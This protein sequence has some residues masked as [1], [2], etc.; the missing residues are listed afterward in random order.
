MEPSVGKRA[1]AE[2][3][4]GKAGGSHLE[5]LVVGHHKVFH[6]TLAG[7]HD[8]HGVG[9]FVGTYAEEMLRRVYREQIHQFLRLD[10]VILDEGLNAV[11]VFLAAHVLMGAEVG[12]DIEALFFAEDAFE[13][14]V[15]KVEGVAAELVG[16]EQSFRA[17]HVAY[18]FGQ[19]VLVEVDD[20][21]ALR[22]KMK[23]RLNEA[24]TDTASPADDADPPA[25]YLLGELFFVRFYI[26]R[27]HAGLAEGHAV[28]Y[29]F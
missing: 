18:E 10:V 7:A 17:A 2:G 19:P 27:E 11:A 4:V 24:G 6:D 26:G 12:H 9:S 23:N 16:D 20:N 3:D 15:G 25:F 1:V 22:L 8:I 14:G 28:G 5:V 13:D 21:D 29:E